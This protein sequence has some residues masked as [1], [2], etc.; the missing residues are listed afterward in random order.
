MPGQSGPPAISQKAGP[1]SDVL[2]T[3]VPS[4]AQGAQQMAWLGGLVGARARVRPHSTPLSPLC[5]IVRHQASGVHVKSMN[6][7]MHV[8]IVLLGMHV[9][10][11]DVRL[12]IIESTRLV[13]TMLCGELD[14]CS[15][16]NCT[17][18]MCTRKVC[19]HGFK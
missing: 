4:R 9:V 6:F 13:A 14:P 1:E 17:A 10:S 16:E 15:H 12:S 8:Y 11:P 7:H 18:E 19:N 2:P 3:P 5:I